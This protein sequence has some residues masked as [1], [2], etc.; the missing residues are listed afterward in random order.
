MSGFV[1]E[2]R[3]R[4]KPVSF[5]VQEQRTLVRLTSLLTRNPP[6]LP[7]LNH[8]RAFFVLTKIDEILS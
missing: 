1:S 3:R 2:N 4:P 6:V 5:D 7:K 8:R